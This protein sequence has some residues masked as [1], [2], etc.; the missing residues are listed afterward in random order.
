MPSSVLSSWLSLLL[1]SMS[2]HTACLLKYQSDEPLSFYYLMTYSGWTRSVHHGFSLEM[3]LQQLLDISSVQ[4]VS[5]H[6][7][8]F[9]INCLH[10]MVGANNGS[11]L[12]GVYLELNTFIYQQLLPEKYKNASRQPVMVGVILISNVRAK[13]RLK[14]YTK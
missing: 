11:Y 9:R 8:H 14:T 4:T 5:V 7:T 12:T 6:V 3:V 13:N 10:H 2:W 1:M